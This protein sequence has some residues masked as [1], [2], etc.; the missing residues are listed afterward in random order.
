MPTQL[1][2]AFMGGGDKG[3]TPSS[4]SAKSGDAS[5]GVTLD[6]SANNS[7]TVGGSGKTSSDAAL[8]GSSGSTNSNSNMALYIALGVAG[9]AIV[10]VIA[11]AALRK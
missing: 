4:N 9:V 8:G 7:F 10:G 6:F 1:L 2:G 11:F 5:S 3:S